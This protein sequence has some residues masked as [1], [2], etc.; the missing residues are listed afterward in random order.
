MSINSYDI[1]S[2]D[3]NTF[4]VLGPGNANFSTAEL[5]ITSTTLAFNASAAAELGYPEYVIILTAP[6][7]SI[8]L[9][10]PYNIENDGG[11]PPT[12]FYNRELKPKR[13]V[14]RDKES[15][16]SLRS[17]LKW[18][19]KEIRKIPGLRIKEHALF[20]DMRKAVR[21]KEKLARRAPSLENYPSYGE[22][23][24]MCV[25]PL[26]ALPAAHNIAV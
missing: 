4:R 6:D 10:R 1:S 8:I 19:D 21:G 13:V 26:R 22:L 12:P 18:I 25:V 5:K 20:F 14:I 24:E 15:A 7:A 2:Y 16:K 17:E 11:F 9:V 3:I 23:Q